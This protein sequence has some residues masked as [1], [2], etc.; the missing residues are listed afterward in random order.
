EPARAFQ[1][2]GDRLRGDVLG[3][4]VAT[5]E[6][7]PGAAQAFPQQ[8]AGLALVPGPG[9]DVEGGAPFGGGA[10]DVSHDD[11]P[12]VV[13]VG[14]SGRRRRG[15][16]DGGP[17]PSL[18]PGDRRA[19]TDRSVPLTLQDARRSLAHSGARLTFRISGLRRPGQKSWWARRAGLFQD[20]AMRRDRL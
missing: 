15:E 9:G 1:D 12:S 13:L 3:V 4:V 2:A 18:L 16:A 5:A 8:L 19:F 14:L 20:S 10:T 17:I 6:H 11:P 7:G